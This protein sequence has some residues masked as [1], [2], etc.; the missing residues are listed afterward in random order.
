MSIASSSRAPCLKGL[1]SVNPEVSSNVRLR[2]L[3]TWALIVAADSSRSQAFASCC[4]SCALL[5][6]LSALSGGWMEGVSLFMLYCALGIH[7]D[8]SGSPE[9]RQSGD[10][11]SFPESPDLSHVGTTAASRHLD[12]NVVTHAL[13]RHIVLKVCSCVQQLSLRPIDQITWQRADFQS[14]CEG[15]VA[16]LTS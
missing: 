13:R 11:T 15:A 6:P 1:C 4:S 8:E 3:E 16:L 12:A 9:E 2:L 10:G 5:H 7:V 14:R